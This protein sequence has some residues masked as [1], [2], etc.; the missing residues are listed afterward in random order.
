MMYVYCQCSKEEY[1]DHLLLVRSLST[2]QRIQCVGMR[3]EKQ[4]RKDC[5]DQ[6]DV[7]PYVYYVMLVNELSRRPDVSRLTPCDLSRS[8][9]LAQSIS[10]LCVLL[11]Y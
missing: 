10:R 8:L 2:R 5:G 7:E 4:T 3:N 1:K 9:S 11:G 6:C